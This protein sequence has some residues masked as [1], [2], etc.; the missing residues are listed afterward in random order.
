MGS[1]GSWD[2]SLSLVKRI[3]IT[4]KEENSSED[5]KKFIEK[6]KNSF[7]QRKS[8]EDL[9]K[10]DVL[11]MVVADDEDEDLYEEITMAELG[12]EN[13][14]AKEFIE[15][16]MW[17]QF[18]DKFEDVLELI[19]IEGLD[20]YVEIKDLENKLKF[21]DLKVLAKNFHGWDASTP[22][23]I[24]DEQNLASCS[25]WIYCH[26]DNSDTDSFTIT[27]KFIDSLSVGDKLV[28]R[29]DGDGEHC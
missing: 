29:G 26:N 24:E 12:L 22:S 8:Y 4:K 25:G 23:F 15:N 18:E 6:N 27:Q 10:N 5:I 7:K 21:L 9:K 17:E 19:D 3:G 11:I 20:F 28:L 1:C 13:V 2:A 14:N 16:K